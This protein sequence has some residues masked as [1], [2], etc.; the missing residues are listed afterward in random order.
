MGSGR[1]R[2]SEGDSQQIYSLP[3]FDRFEYTPRAV[4]ME[5]ARGIEPPTW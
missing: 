2:T 5:L 1:I 3:S 4:G